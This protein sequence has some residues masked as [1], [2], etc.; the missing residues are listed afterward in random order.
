MGICVG[1]V[2]GSRIWGLGTANWPLGNLKLS[3]A[4]ATGLMFDPSQATC[5]PPAKSR[6]RSIGGELGK[7]DRCHLVAI[8]ITGAKTLVR[9]EEEQLVSKQGAP[10]RSSELVLLQDGLG[11]VGKF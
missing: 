6:C 10:H 8:A 1:S 3:K 7:V 4:N 5:S 9:A 11:L 2:E